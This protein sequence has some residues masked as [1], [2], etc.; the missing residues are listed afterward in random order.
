MSICMPDNKNL[1]VS[2]AILEGFLKASIK[3]NIIAELKLRQSKI[4]TLF[5]GIRW[6][7]CWICSRSFLTI[8]NMQGPYSKKS[9]N[10]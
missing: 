3:L 6:K 8:T 5:S 7:T 2:G 10:P 1:Q 9:V 4:L